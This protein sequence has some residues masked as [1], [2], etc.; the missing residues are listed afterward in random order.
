[1]SPLVTVGLLVGKPALTLS[2]LLLPLS[3]VQ[4]EILGSS[5]TYGQKGQ[6]GKAEL[7]LS[8]SEHAVSLAQTQVFMDMLGCS[9]L[10]GLQTGSGPGPPCPHVLFSLSGFQLR[11][12]NGQATS[13]SL[14][15]LFSLPS[16]H[17]LSSVASDYK[18][19]ASL[20]PLILYPFFS[21]SS[22]M[23]PLFTRFVK[24]SIKLICKMGTK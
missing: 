7:W 18:G 19:W 23:A 4:W 6:L 8:L 20:F 5:M 17:P 2:C 14:F 15:L 24:F 12:R 13:P 21:A 22:F 11:A 3:R 1:M 16:S 9:P 10:P